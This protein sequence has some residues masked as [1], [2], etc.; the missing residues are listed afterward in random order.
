SLQP[1]RG[2]LSSTPFPYTPLFRSKREQPSDE[3]TA[4]QVLQHEHDDV[5]DDEGFVDGG[6]SLEHPGPMQS[7]GKDFNPKS[8]KKPVVHGLRSEEHTS[9]L[10][11]RENLVCRLL[12][13]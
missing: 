12:L 10:Q 5:R 2:S 8:K 9:E 7:P 6:D 4:R 11:S 13:E 3:G 1:I